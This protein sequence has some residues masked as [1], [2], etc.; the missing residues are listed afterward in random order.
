MSRMNIVVRQCWRHIYLGARHVLGKHNGIVAARP[1]VP[2]LSFRSLALE[3][4]SG[5]TCA[6]MLLQP[7]QREAGA[8]QMEAK[9]QVPPWRGGRVGRPGRRPP[10]P[11]LAHQSRERE[12]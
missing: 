1:H 9:L 2:L 5:C 6:Q 10:A 8:S 7:W 3:A 4:G 11:A 12:A